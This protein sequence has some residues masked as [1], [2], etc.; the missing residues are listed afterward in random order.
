[1]QIQNWCWFRYTLVNYCNFTEYI[2]VIAPYLINVCVNVLWPIPHLAK[3]FCSWRFLLS[4]QWV[5]LTKECISWSSLLIC[6]SQRSC[7][8]LKIY[9]MTVIK[10]VYAWNRNKMV[11]VSS[12]MS[13]VSWST[14]PLPWIS[15]WLGIRVKMACLPNATR[16]SSIYIYKGSF[17]F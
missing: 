13:F 5:L 7:Q 15:I 3:T 6:R 8:C 16:L 14:T 4:D 12:N 2:A 1:M 9:F 11:I 17:R 10:A